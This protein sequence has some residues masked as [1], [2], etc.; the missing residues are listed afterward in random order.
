MVVGLAVAITA[1]SHSAMMPVF[2]KLAT[3]VSVAH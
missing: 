1:T 3:I 2:G